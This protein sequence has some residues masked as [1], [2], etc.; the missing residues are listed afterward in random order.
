[1]LN[2]DFRFSQD[3]L[4]RLYF[5]HVAIVT[6]IQAS[7]LLEET[8]YSSLIRPPEAPK[9][10]VRDSRPRRASSVGKSF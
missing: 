8:E 1:M 2:E 6:D 4:V 10:T 3:S 5:I 9:P 7:L